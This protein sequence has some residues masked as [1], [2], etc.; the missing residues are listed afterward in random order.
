VR[1]F[2]FQEGNK[3]KDTHMLVSALKFRFSQCEK[4]KFNFKRLAAS[5]QMKKPH[6]AITAAELE[7]IF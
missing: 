6:R 1:E 4:K 3:G 7:D 5:S 2:I